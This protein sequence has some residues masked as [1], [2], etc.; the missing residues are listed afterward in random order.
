MNIKLFQLAAK[1][2]TNRAQGSI[3]TL[4]APIGP[5]MKQLSLGIGSIIIG[6]VCFLFTIL[7]LALSF[8]FYLADETKWSISGLWTC[9]V[10]ALIGTVFVLIGRSALSNS[11]T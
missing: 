8:F 6:V 1:Y 10:F 9:L 4:L 2:L 11:P 5:M 3:L 7:F